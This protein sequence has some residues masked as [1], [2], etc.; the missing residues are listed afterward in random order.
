M[1]A[2]AAEVDSKNRLKSVQ[3]GIEIRQLINSGFGSVSKA[4][5]RLTIIEDTRDRPTKAENG[6]SS[7]RIP[8][9]GTN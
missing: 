5:N 8:R 1:G 3:R 2:L 4:A 7:T 9:I 6:D